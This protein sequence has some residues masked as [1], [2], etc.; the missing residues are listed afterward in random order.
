MLVSLGEHIYSHDTK[1]YLIPLHPI[2][3]SI[4]LFNLNTAFYRFH[5]FIFGYARWEHLSWHSVT[6]HRSIFLFQF[7]F[8]IIKA[9]DIF[10]N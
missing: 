5:D 2:F 9:I 7:K 10:I 8:L 3:S 4:R 1:S 6:K